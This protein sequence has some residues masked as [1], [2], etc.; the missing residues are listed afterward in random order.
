MANADFSEILGARV[1][2]CIEAAG[3]RTIE[4]FAFA[5]GLSKSTLSELLNGKTKPSVETVARIAARLKIPLWELL[6]DSEL[7]LSVREMDPD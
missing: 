7:D 1:R 6:R 4:E 3:Y 2:N 5:K